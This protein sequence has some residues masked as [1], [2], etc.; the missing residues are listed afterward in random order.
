M[1]YF[2]TTT[3][4]WIFWT[5]F[6]CSNISVL[7]LT[8]QLASNSTGWAQSQK[9]VATS[10]TLLQVPLCHGY[11]WLINSSGNP[12]LRFQLVG[13][14]S[15]I[16]RIHPRNS[17][18]E[19]MQMAKC[20]WEVHG[21]S[22]TFHVPPSKHPDVFLGLASGNWTQPSAPLL[23]SSF[24]SS[25]IGRSGRLRVPVYNH[26]LVYLA[27]SPHSKIIEGLPAACPLSIQNTHLLFRKSGGF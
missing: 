2:P 19:E 11:F 6:G 5:P 20:E 21:A 27:A 13:M 22:M 9:N 16:E 8:S 25:C 15:I 7:T 23:S 14:T 12:L 4:S 17:Q 18:M 10:D 1:W 3:N 24:P 26:A